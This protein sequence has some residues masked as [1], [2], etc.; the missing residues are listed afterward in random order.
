MRP[1]STA[2]I[3]PLTWAGES[4]DWALEMAA[5]YPTRFGRSGGSTRERRTP[6]QLAGW[7]RH[8]HMLACG[9]L[10]RRRLWTGLTVPRLVLANAI[11]S[12]FPS[13]PL[14]LG[15]LTGCRF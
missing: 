5:R 14:C 9:C 3:V 1:A 7:F 4:N 12:H 15:S 11:V 8:K 2:V 10:P 13:W 6:A